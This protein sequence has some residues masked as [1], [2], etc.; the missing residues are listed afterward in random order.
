MHETYQGSQIM[1]SK[2]TVIGKLVLFCKL[3]NF[4]LLQNKASLHI[5][6]NLL[7]TIWLYPAKL[8]AC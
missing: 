6:V 4:I 7:A 1:E 5:A 3:C 8:C 2:L